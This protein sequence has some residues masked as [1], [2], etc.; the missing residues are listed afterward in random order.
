MLNEVGKITTT[1]RT[2]VMQRDSKGLYIGLKLGA[3]KIVN[4]LIKWVVLDNEQIK[5]NRM[6][7]KY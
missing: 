5:L 1:N 3:G 4:Q 2:D 7:D 6:L